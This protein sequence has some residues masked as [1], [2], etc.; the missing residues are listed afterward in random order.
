MPFRRRRRFK[1]RKPGTLRKRVAAIM[2]SAS[3][4]KRTQILFVDA[5]VTAAYTVQVI[6]SLAQGV[7]L[8][9]RIGAFVR[10]KAIK[11]DLW[12][13]N[14]NTNDRFLRTVLVKPKL[15]TGATQAALSSFNAPVNTTDYIVK[16][17]RLY[18]LSAL[19]ATRGGGPPSAAHM[20]Y[21]KRFPG[22]GQK[23]TF[24]TAAST[25]ADAGTWYLVTMMDT[26]SAAD[27]T[28]TGSIQVMYKDM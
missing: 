14:K 20:L 4:T 12:F 1:R 7:D 26:V 5:A 2:N 19:T 10:M 8:D 6:M 21:N 3:E 18:R 9:Q 28:I 24:D 23:V 27:V 11:L 17:D 16:F 22:S 25:E 13:T 15:Q